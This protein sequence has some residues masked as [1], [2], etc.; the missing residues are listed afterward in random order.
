MRTP[1]LVVLLVRSEITLSLW[2]FVL[3]T[4]GLRV[5]G[6]VSPKQATSFNAKEY[7][8]PIVVM[9]ELEAVSG[10]R[11]FLREVKASYPHVRSLV[12][13]SK[14]TDTSLDVL[15]NVFLPKSL[16]DAAIV[17]SRL[18]VLAMRKRGPKPVE[19]RAA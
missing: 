9:A 17:I 19:R 13:S 10:K 14:Y 7:L 16:T 3:E 18:K 2:R 5:L 8:A 4:H 6:S 11:T 15:A 12:F 1:T